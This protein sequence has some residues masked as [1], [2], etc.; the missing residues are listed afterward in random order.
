MNDIGSPIVEMREHILE[1]FKLGC[2]QRISREVLNHVEVSTFVGLVGHDVAMD[3]VATL[4]RHKVGQDT[5]ERDVVLAVDVPTSAWQ[6]FKDAHAG[7]WWFAWF[8]NR[9]PAKT[10]KITK[11]A[12]F[13]VDVRKYNVFPQATFRYPDNFGPAIKW[14]DYPTCD[15]LA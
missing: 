10:R 1:A 2:G 5:I 8:A 11:T 9:W 6:F 13:A 14:I 12:H 3:F 15:W 4:Y 7:A